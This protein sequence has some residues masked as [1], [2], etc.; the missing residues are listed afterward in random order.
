MKSPETYFVPANQSLKLQTLKCGSKGQF[1][2]F[3]VCGGCG[4]DTRGEDMSECIF[5]TQITVRKSPAFSKVGGQGEVT[6]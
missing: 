2:K 3:C 4:T 5:T 6:S 1:L